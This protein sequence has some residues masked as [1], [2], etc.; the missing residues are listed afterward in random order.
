MNLS[1]DSII[2]TQAST[3]IGVIVGGAIGAVVF[4]AV[5]VF[6]YLKKKYRV[7]SHSRQVIQFKQCLFLLLG[8]LISN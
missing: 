7:N 3:N 5:I 6:L 8:S 1:T 2:T 4:S